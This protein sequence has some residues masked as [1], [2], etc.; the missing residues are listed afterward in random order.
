LGVTVGGRYHLVSVLG[1]G[2]MGTVYLARH[3]VIGRSYAVK[4]LRREIAGDPDSVR[5]FVREAKIAGSLSH[6]HVAE[7]LDFGEVTSQELPALGS[8]TQPFM[9]MPLLEG[10]TL[11]DILDRDGPLEGPRAARL[12]AQAA[13]GLAAAHARDVVHRD[14]KPDN[15]FVTRGAE[16]EGSP[17]ELVKVLDFGVAKLLSGPRL[18]KQGTVFG[19]PYYMSPEQALGQPIDGRTDQYALGVVLYEVLAGRVPFDD[20]TPMAVMKK[21]I[22]AT[23]TPLEEVVPDPEKLGAVGPIVLRCLEKRADARFRDM[24]ELAAALED[25]AKAGVT[26]RP[27]ATVRMDA[28]PTGTIKMTQASPI[29]GAFRDALAAEEAAPPRAPAAARPPPRAR[30]WLAPLVAALAVA[31]AAIVSWLATR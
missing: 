6:P 20:D 2:G 22:F 21:H 28:G 10:R 4:V 14:L 12:F 9:V 25:A 7:V 29:S 15:L 18:T 1:Q 5:R 3:E 17:R 23:P 16:A 26:P 19:T 27:R 24:D 11:A 30:R 31:A 13:R 8:A